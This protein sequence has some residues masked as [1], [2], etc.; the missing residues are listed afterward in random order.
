MIENTRF[1]YWIELAEY[2]LETAKAM[3]KTKRFLYVG[4]M[5]HQ[6]I[7]KTI[8]AYH[9][10]T[11]NTEPPYIHNLDRLAQKAEIIEDLSE[12]QLDLLDELNP[13]NIEARYPKDKDQILKDLS[14]KKCREILT[15]TQ[16]LM[17]W[18]KTK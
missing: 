5:C 12:D 9:W 3:L 6:C 17:K 2:D 15:K 16:E 10:K 11:H 1:N 14:L 13:L 7:E 18:I 4:F 8:K